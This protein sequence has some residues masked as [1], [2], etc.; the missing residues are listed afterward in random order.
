[1]GLQM[2]MQRKEM[3]KSTLAEQK[4]QCEVSVYAANKEI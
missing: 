1:M 2:E 3:P 4:R